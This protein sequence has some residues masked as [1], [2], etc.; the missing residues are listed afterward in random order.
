MQ[1]ETIVFEV[2]GMSC[3]HC[4]AAVTRA[5]QAVRPGAAVEIDLATRRVEIGAE[6]TRAAELRAAIEDAGYTV[7]SG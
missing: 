2:D 4:V 1:P 3:G 5:V 6:P 7:V